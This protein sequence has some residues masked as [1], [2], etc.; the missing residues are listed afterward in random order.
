MF[1][2]G[3]ARWRPHLRGEL[4]VRQAARLLG[5]IL[6]GGSQRLRASRTQPK[7]V[8]GGE[9]RASRSPVV[10]NRPDGWVRSDITHRHHEEARVDVAVEPA[11]DVVH[12]PRGGDACADVLTERGR[13][14]PSTRYVGSRQP[15]AAERRTR[16]HSAARSEAAEP[17]T[18]AVSSVTKH[19]APALMSWSQRGPACD[20]GVGFLSNAAQRN[21]GAPGQL[22]V[23]P[24][25]AEAGPAPRCGSR[26]RCCRA[27]GS[28][29]WC[30]AEGTAPA[31]RGRKGGR[32]QERADVPSLRRRGVRRALRAGAGQA[33]RRRARVVWSTSADTAVRSS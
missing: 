1:L 28:A 9:V 24:G 25:S 33:G 11:D 14:T 29:S 21:R 16:R 12:G 4:R 7:G 27:L 31:Q 13:G 32:P 2:R 23:R 26:E 18:F 15:S 6:R 3:A 5:G 8:R 19:G 17:R 22:R 30:C 10:V 20:R